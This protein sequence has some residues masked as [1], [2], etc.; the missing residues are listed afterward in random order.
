MY[1]RFQCQQDVKVDLLTNVFYS[2]LTKTTKGIMRNAG[3]CGICGDPYDGPRLHE[4]GNLMAPNETTR[5]YY[6]GS[7]I[8]V[9]IE[10]VANHG[11][12]FQFEMCWRDEWKDIETEDCFEELQLSARTEKEE[13]DKRTQYELDPRAKTGTFTMSLDL[14]ENRTCDSCILR[15]HWR[16]GNN[17]GVCED[18]THAIGCGHQEVYRNCADV[19]VKRN[20]A[21]IGFGMR[22]QK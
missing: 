6:P 22:H 2:Y 9:M 11:G 5:N 13:S 7:S 3:K 16:S 20:G 1:V 21:G 4:T 18:G 8:D 17:W 10:I 12:K 14:P 19:S 15:W